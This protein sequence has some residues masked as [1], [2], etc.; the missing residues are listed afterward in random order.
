MVVSLRGR[1]SL[2]YES[3]T[4]WQVVYIEELLNMHN[5]KPRLTLCVDAALDCR[6]EV[7]LA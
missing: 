2:I 3:Y 1:A 6:D 5:I 4:C 7:L